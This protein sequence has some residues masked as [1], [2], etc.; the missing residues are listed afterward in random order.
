MMRVQDDFLGTWYLQRSIDDLF[1]GQDAKFQGAAV[2]GQA[3]GGLTYG[4]QGKMRIGAGPEM[5]AERRY[6]WQWQDSVVQVLFADGAA[7]HSFVP[8]GEAIGTTHLCGD[9]LYDVTY[10]FSRWPRWQA[11][12]RVSG[13]KK[14]YVSTSVYTRD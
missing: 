5:Q 3:D 10:D 8:A 2:F 12:W 11:V 1:S 9:D 4:E 13:P 14:N 6:L 7:F